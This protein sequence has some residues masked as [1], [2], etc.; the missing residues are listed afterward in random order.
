MAQALS[1]VRLH[2]LLAI[3]VLLALTCLPR[4]AW[5][6]DSKLYLK[7]GT[8]QLVKSYEVH[9]DR[10]RFYSLERSEWEE[11]P[12]SLVDFEA[13]KRAQQEENVSAK[14]ELEEAH[15]LDERFEKPAELGFQVAAG[16]H[17]PAEEGVY[18][19]DGVR[20]IRLVQ[21]SAEVVKDKKRAALM[22]AL[23]GPL[24][25]NR[26]AVMLEGPRAAVRI[27]VVQPVFYANF[28]DGSGAQLNLIPLKPNK[29]A[30]AVEKIEGGI[31]MGQ[32]GE[33][34]T[35][36]PVERVQ[37][38]PG[39]FRIKPTQ[40]LALGE[41]A[42]GE[43]TGEKLNLDLWDFGIDGAMDRNNPQGLSPTPDTPPVIRRKPPVP[44]AP[45]H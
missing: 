29:T 38:A 42:L 28:A 15:K 32:S 13:T 37:V 40:E 10:V 18:A 14:K 45:Q 27:M 39:I 4:A 9:G 3:A 31:G 2:L 5:A 44:E 33:S 17:L 19:F 20:V 35:E 24:L 8:Y 43:L 30:R 23:P 25:K 41:Y 21:S 1:R 36:L 16:I 7:D 12:A 26:S 6:S 22:L 34:R 11:M